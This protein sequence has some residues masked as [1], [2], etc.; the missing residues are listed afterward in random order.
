MSTQQN[1][2]TGNV[3][4]QLGQYQRFLEQL[5]IGFFYTQHFSNNWDYPQNRSV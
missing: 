3:S 4:H 1:R 5:G 2:E